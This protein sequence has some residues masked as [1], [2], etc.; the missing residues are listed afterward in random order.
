[1]GTITTNQIVDAGGSWTNNQFNGANG[2]FEIEF[3]QPTG[4]SSLA[5]YPHAGLIDEVVGTAGP[6]VIYTASDD[7]GLISA[8]YRY[9]IRPSWTLNTLLGT[10]DSAGLQQGTSAGNADNVDVWN[11]ATQGYT[12]YYYRTGNGWRGPA[13]PTINVGTNA[14][15]LDQG[16]V[17]ARR[18]GT[19]TN[20]LLVGAV[21]DADNNQP[22]VGQT[23][24]PIIQSGSTFAGNVY[25]SS[26]SLGSSGLFTTNTATGVQSGTSAGNA[27]NVDIWNPATQGYAVY[28]Y[29]TSNGWRGPAGPTIDASTNQI[30]LGSSVLILRRSG[31]A[32]NWFVP[33]PY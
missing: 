22:G 17:I 21:K 7:S 8:G 29:R 24:V 19:S 11:P 31:T 16:I 33:Q 2:P 28:Y 18:A 3:L 30:P 4:S 5:S 14:L 32:F 25:A 13:G 27:D 10:N 12:V 1:V 9:Q 23:I 15:F 26:F 6:N 20:V